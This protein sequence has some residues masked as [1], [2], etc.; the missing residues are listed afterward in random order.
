MLHNRRLSM[1]RVMAA[2]MNVETAAA[3][4]KTGH[5]QPNTA[6]SS[7]TCRAITGRNVAGTM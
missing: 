5:D 6:G 3:T 2:A 1:E 7:T 4:P